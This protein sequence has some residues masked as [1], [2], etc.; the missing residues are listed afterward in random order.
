[1]ILRD[2]LGVDWHNSV[3]GNF[4]SLSLS[5]AESFDL[6]FEMLSLFVYEF[7]ITVGQKVRS[8]FSVQS[9]VQVSNFFFSSH[10]FIDLSAQ[11]QDV[12]DLRLYVLP[13]DEAA[14]Q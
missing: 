4:H 1:M 5:H 14:V 2:A 10:F 3:Y 11:V 12:V 7:F 9:V 13:F 6:Q 8:D